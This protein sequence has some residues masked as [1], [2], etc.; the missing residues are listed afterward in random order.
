MLQEFSTVRQ[1][2]VGFRRLFSDEH[3]DLYLWF[4]SRRGRLTGYQLCYDKGSDY[5]CLTWTRDTGY[6]HEAV[7]DGE[8]GGAGGGYKGTPILVSDRA[9]DK[10]VLAE[11]F[12]G[13]S[14]KVPHKLRH[15][16]YMGILACDIDR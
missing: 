13:V 16:V 14:E 10:A 11:R 8:S 7:D 3:F 12:W 9:F 2:Q 5:H 15:L 1:E 6:R 4:R